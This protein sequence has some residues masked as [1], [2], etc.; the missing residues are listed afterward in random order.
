ML[1]LARRVSEIRQEVGYSFGFGRGITL[2]WTA[3]Q[4]ADLDSWMRSG[5]SQFY[6]PGQI[7]GQMYEWSFL[8]QVGR[9]S[10]TSGSNTATLPRSF[11]SY[12]GNLV[13]EST[14]NS[15]DLEYVNSARMVEMQTRQSEQTGQPRFYSVID[16]PAQELTRKTMLVWPVPD[17]D[18]VVKGLYQVNPETVLE[19][20]YPYGAAEHSE[21]IL[22]SCYSAAELSGDNK[23]NGPFMMRFKELLVASVNS[24]RQLKDGSVGT[25]NKPNYQG[26]YPFIGRRSYAGTVTF[27]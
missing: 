16:A 14:T 7:L 25:F 26:W 17:A 13:I 6:R 5:M 27:E 15:W 9:F 22:Y 20:E 21:T 1:G 12:V 19:E 24:D 2:A 18:Y 4:E 11:G 8:R 23:F 3:Q 10:I